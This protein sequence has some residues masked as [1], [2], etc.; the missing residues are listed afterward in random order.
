MNTL[1]DQIHEIEKRLNRIKN[2][3]GSFEVKLTNMEEFEKKMH[4]YEGEM[5]V[6]NEEIRELERSMMFCLE[7]DKIESTLVV[8][9]EQLVAK[10]VNVVKEMK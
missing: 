3:I 9:Y 8:R 4:E 10:R 6:I 2:D 7:L 5:G 1:F